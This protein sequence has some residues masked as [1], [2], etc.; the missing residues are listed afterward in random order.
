MSGI[1]FTIGPPGAGKSTWADKHLSKECLRIER[2]RF[3]EALFGSRKA[4]WEHPVPRR[5]RSLAVGSAMYQAAKAWPRHL[6]IAMTDTCIH[7]RTVKNFWNLRSS[8]RLVIFKTS[9]ETLLERNLTRPEEH[10]LPED[11]VRTYYQDFINPEA[12][13]QKVRIGVDV[14]GIEVVDDC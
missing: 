12:W 14:W 8:R 5:V 9:L 13:F 4:Y 3:R 10:R 11:D 1:T 2:D 6:P 7:W